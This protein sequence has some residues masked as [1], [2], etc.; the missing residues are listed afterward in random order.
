[1]KRG[2]TWR[3]FSIRE[4]DAIDGNLDS[5]LS[6]PTSRDPFEAIDQ[7]PCITINAGDSR[8]NISK[9]KSATPPIFQSGSVGE[10]LVSDLDGVIQGGGQ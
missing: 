4:I 7:I 10:Y 1:M 3:H 8:K 9:S 5:L 6:N 2:C